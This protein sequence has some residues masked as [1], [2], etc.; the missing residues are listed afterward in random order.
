MAQVVYS[1]V[2][3]HSAALPPRF[4]RRTSP[5]AD[6]LA[7]R[8]LPLSQASTAGAHRANDQTAS[9][10]GPRTERIDLGPILARLAAYA[11][12]KQVLES[13][14][15]A[16]DWAAGKPTQGPLLSWLIRQLGWYSIELEKV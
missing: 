2:R 9:A 11:P 10:S 14:R 4:R 6:S 5:N 7:P 3:N 15:R 1:I 8:P 13:E 12:D 16:K